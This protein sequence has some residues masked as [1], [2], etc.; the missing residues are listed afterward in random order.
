[1]KEEYQS[2]ILGIIRAKGN[3]SAAELYHLIDLGEST[4]RKYL[5]ELVEENQLHISGAG[6]STKYFIAPSF[7]LLEFIDLNVYYHKEIDVRNAKNT[8]NFELISEVLQNASLFT[9]KEQVKLNKIQGRYLKSIQSVESGIYKKRLEVLA[10]DLIWKSS[11]IEGNTYSLLET[12]ALIK[13][14]ELAKGKSKEDATMLLNHKKAL[15]FITDDLSYLKPLTVNK[16]IDIHTLLIGGLGVSNNIR[17]RAVA[18]TGTNYRPISIE[19][20]I[21]E[22]LERIVNLVNSKENIYEKGLLLLCLISYLQAFEDGNKRTAR[23]ISNAVLMCYNHCPLSFRT[24]SAVDYKKAMLLFYE[25]NNISAM[26]DIFINQYE[27]AVNQY[28]DL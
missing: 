7:A 20:Q 8:Y 21:K 11:E 9:A 24:V 4:V 19:S 6:R 12:E 3:V 5:K 13:Q 15:D 25:Q 2:E 1:M 22:E 18:I 16:I 26:K 28:F 17:K 10:I 27:F 14:Q 23:I